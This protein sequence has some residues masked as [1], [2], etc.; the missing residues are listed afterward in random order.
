MFNKNAHFK[1]LKPICDD[2]KNVYN[3][4]YICDEYT[5]LTQLKIVNTVSYA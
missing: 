5:N 2:I 4:N 3:T 1:I